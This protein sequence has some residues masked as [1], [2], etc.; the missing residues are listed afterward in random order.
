MTLLFLGDLLPLFG[1]G[2]LFS[3]PPL[4]TVQS[5][6]FLVLIVISFFGSFEWHKAIKSAGHDNIDATKERAVIKKVE[7]RGSIY[8]TYIVTYVSV[9]PLLS[10][11][12]EGLVSFAIILLIVYSL[13]INSDMIFYNPILAFCGYRFYR[14]EIEQNQAP[15]G[16]VKEIYAISKLKIKANKTSSEPNYKFYTITDFTYLIV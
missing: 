3:I 11:S 7:D 4:L 10:K 14:I 8:T 5:I 9:I 1:I 15:D 12:W 2:M 13:Y 6:F 16:E